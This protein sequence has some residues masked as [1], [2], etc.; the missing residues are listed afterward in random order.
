MLARVLGQEGLERILVIE[1][2]RFSSIRWKRLVY[3]FT[4]LGL[5][6]VSDGSV[7]FIGAS[8]ARRRGM[9]A[10]NWQLKLINKLH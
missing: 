7:G 6:A 1:K 5:T 9:G 10:V 2:F 3:K 4:G 8:L